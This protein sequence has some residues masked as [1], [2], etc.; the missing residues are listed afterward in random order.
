[1]RNDSLFSV[2]AHLD[3]PE[4]KSGRHDKA[5]RVSSA[6]KFLLNMYVDQMLHALRYKTSML[7]TV[8]HPKKKK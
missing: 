3:I 6:G 8:D 7:H 2:I 5:R 4:K 1:M